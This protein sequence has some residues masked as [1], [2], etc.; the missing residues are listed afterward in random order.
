MILFTLISTTKWLDGKS[1]MHLELPRLIIFSLGAIPGLQY[2][3]NI[4][5]IIVLIGYVLLNLLVLPFLKNAVDNQHDA[6]THE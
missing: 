5:G 2:Y 4:I 1:A 3:E 6:F